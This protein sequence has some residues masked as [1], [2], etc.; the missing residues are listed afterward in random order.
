[1]RS[2]RNLDLDLLKDIPE[3]QLIVI[4]REQNVIADALVVS[5]ILFKITIHATKKYEIQVKNMPIILDN[6]KYWQ[7]FED[8]Q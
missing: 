8:D 1:M 5:V 4:P 2:Y 7:V 6:V 3:H